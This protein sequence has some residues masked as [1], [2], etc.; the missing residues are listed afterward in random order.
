MLRMGDN[1]TYAAHR[2][3]AAGAVAG[4]GIQPRATSRRFPPSAPPIRG[5]RARPSAARP[6]AACSDGGVRRLAAVG[7]G[8]RRPAADVLARRPEA[9]ALADADHAAHVR[10][11]LVRHR[12]V[13]G[14]AARAACSTRRACCPSARFVSFYSFDDW[15]DSI[16]LL[17]ALHPQTLLAYGMN[18]RDLPVPH[19]AP[20]RLRVETPARLQEHEIPAAH[21]RQRQVRRRREEREHSERLVVVRGDLRRRACRP[22]AEG[23]QINLRPGD[24]PRVLRDRARDPGKGCSPG[25]SAL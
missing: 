8:P 25:G 2:D 3:A 22:V 10:G 21:R 17:D 23:D 19:G 15:A 4:Q 18:G 24:Q 13:D 20:V 16:D 7:R 1:L 6:I 5:D 11:R 12:R 14:R 9:V